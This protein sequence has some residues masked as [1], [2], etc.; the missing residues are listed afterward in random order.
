MKL[1]LKQ[2]KKKKKVFVSKLCQVSMG[3]STAVLNLFGYNLQFLYCLASEF[4]HPSEVC[5][6]YFM[7]V[8]KLLYCDLPANNYTLLSKASIRCMCNSLTREVAD[9]NSLT[10]LAHNMQIR[11]G[12]FV[13][14]EVC[15]M[16]KCKS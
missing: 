9:T 14:T 7:T 15:K 8:L 11:Y 16:W 4:R 6:P 12:R 10:Q 1:H 2:A 13:H 3:S 5:H